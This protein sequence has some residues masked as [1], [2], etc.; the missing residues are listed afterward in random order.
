MRYGVE[1]QVVL[2]FLG[3]GRFTKFSYVYSENLCK[4]RQIEIPVR[5]ADLQQTRKF[6]QHE[7]KYTWNRSLGLK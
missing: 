2:D 1:A 7:G 4:L 3:W 5:N 6:L